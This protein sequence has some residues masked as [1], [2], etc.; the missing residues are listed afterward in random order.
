[1]RRIH[2]WNGR[3]I[4]IVLLTVVSLGSGPA[5]ATGDPG[6]LSTGLS[7]DGIPAV[8]LI[9][10][11]CESM[12]SVYDDASMYE[13][14]TFVHADDNLTKFVVDPTGDRLFALGVTTRYPNIGATNGEDT[15]EITAT[16]A[17]SGDLLW[18]VRRPSSEVTLYDIGVSKDGKI[19]YVHGGQAVRKRPGD[20][21][22]LRNESPYLAAYKAAT[23]EFL[24]ERRLDGEYQ[25]HI[26]GQSYDLHSS[27]R[28]SGIVV[29]DGI[30]YL[31]G[32]MDQLH[33]FYDVLVAAF[34]GASGTL[35]WQTSFDT[36]TPELRF[37]ADRAVMRFAQLTEDARTLVVQTKSCSPT[38]PDDIGPNQAP[39][40]RHLLGIDADARGPDGG[41]L[42]WSIPLGHVP[43]DPPTAW[44]PRSMDIGPGVVYVSGTNN[45]R[46]YSI[47]SG[48]LLWS[49]EQVGIVAASPTGDHVF[50][51]DADFSLVT[52]EASTGAVLRTTAHGGPPGDTILPAD[53]EV[54]VSGTRVYAIGTAGVYAIS[55]AGV[56]QN[57]PVPTLNAEEPAQHGALTAAYEVTTGS[58]I[59]VA[60]WGRDADMEEARHIEVG[61]SG[62]VTV[63]VDLRKPSYTNVLPGNNG[64]WALIAYQP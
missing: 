49:I 46:A 10:D 6:L 45:T 44:V 33:T 39:C 53:L 56:V 9:D 20:G 3:A 51:L 24:W 29:G 61:P 26:A 17:S 4:A 55:T 34:D 60:R 63:S 23:G 8:P 21:D 13:N 5:S 31:T 27:D 42:R 30:V 59:W 2:L 47:D 58:R 36:S 18:V 7:C 48:A 41:Q 12:V 35:L 19:V 11:R 40:P 50:L 22:P 62:T 52:V 43:T 25:G 64:D 1:M 54:D 32:Y 28:G 16:R 14:E 57:N 37:R 38:Q 15:F